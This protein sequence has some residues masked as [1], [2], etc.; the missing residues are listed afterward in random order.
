MIVNDKADLE[1][2]QVSK[3]EIKA[4]GVKQQDFTKLEFEYQDVYSK[5]VYEVGFMVIASSF[6]NVEVNSLPYFI[7]TIDR[8]KFKRTSR[9]RFFEVEETSIRV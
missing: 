7:P 6:E 3:L 1:I 8:S 9:A 5:L 2:P 4:M